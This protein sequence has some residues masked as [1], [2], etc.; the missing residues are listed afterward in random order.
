MEIVLIILFSYMIGNISPSYIFAKKYKNID[1][2]NVESGN[3][4]TTNALRV[5]GKKVAL[6]VFLVDFFKGFFTVFV[7]KYFWGMDYALVSAVFV[8]LGH[9]YPVMLGFR[10]GKG[11]ATTLGILF[12]LFIKEIL[13]CAVVGLA[14]LYIKRYVSL[15]ALVTLFIVNIVII[16]FNNP[17][18]YV[19]FTFFIFCIVAYKHKENIKRL[20]NH[21]ER[22]LGEKKS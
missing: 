20:I 3:A 9:I 8:V 16:L 5:M 2:R 21:T 14:L 13:L 11:V 18:H 7:V 1:I 22:K 17:L 19:A 15:A 12:C 10:G 6:F 4:G